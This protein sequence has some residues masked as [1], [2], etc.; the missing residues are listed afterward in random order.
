L[1]KFKPLFQNSVIIFQSLNPSWSQILSSF[2]S[3]FNISPLF[4][5][6]PSLSTPFSFLPMSLFKFLTLG[7]SLFH[8]SSLVCYFSPSEVWTLCLCVFLYCEL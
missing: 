4:F 3:L 2:Y 7:S 8:S 5:P 6:F 1:S